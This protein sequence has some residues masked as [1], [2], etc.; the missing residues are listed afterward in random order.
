MESRQNLFLPNDRYPIRILNLRVK[1]GAEV[2]KDEVL[3]IYEYS[4]TV[5]RKRTTTVGGRQ[6]VEDVSTQK[7]V[8]DEWR[9]RFAGKLERLLVNNGQRVKDPR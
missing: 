8:T 1:A 6:V 7:L 9:S 5:T 2:H 3:G 4:Q